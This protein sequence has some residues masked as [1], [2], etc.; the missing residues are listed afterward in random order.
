MVFWKK[1]NSNPQ[2]PKAPTVGVTSVKMELPKVVHLIVCSV[3]QLLSSCKAHKLPHQCR[4]LCLLL[5]AISQLF[6]WSADHQI[7]FTCEYPRSYFIFTCFRQKQY[8]LLKTAFLYLAHLSQVHKV[9]TVVFVFSQQLVYI[10]WCCTQFCHGMTQKQEKL[11]VSR[12]RVA[13]QVAQRSCKFSFIRTDS[14]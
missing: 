13:P 7:S 14:L 8:L 10:F 11:A 12:L 1:K 6:L 4:E 3:Q 5:S 2:T 9:N